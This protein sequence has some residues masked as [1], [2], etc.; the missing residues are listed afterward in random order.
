VDLWVFDLATLRFR[1]DTDKRSLSVS[2][3]AG[4]VLATVAI[5]EGTSE[6]EAVFLALDAALDEGR[7]IR[8]GG[9]LEIAFANPFTNQVAVGAVPDTV[10][11]S[12]GEPVEIKAAGVGGTLR[13]GILTIDSRSLIPVET[14]MAT[15]AAALSA[16]RF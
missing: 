3:A 12:D 15:V 13:N 4:D 11:Y 8:E 16:H 2:S 10:A 14:A 9:T 6:R 5:P 1:A 7:L